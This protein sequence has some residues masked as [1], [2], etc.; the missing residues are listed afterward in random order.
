MRHAVRDD[1]RFESNDGV[2]ILQSCPNLFADLDIIE[3]RE[4]SRKFRQFEIG[5][6]QPSTESKHFS[7]NNTKSRPQT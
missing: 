3:I 1:R 7:Q 5:V 6:T 2:I 4:P